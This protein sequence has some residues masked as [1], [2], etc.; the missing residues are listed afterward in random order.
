M[1]TTNLYNYCL[2]TY[3]LGLFNLLGFIMGSLMDPPLG[4]LLFSSLTIRQP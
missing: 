1:F 2:L 4:S 3:V